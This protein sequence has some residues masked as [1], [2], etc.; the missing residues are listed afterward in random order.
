M[1]A[2]LPRRA[3]ERMLKELPIDTKLKTLAALPNLAEFLK[4]TELPNITH[5]TTDNL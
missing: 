5:C 4:D 3:K 1:L 2:L